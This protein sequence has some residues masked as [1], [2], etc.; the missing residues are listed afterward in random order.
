[1]I[2]NERGLNSV[3]EEGTTEE[4]KKE[5]A[6]YFLQEKKNPNSSPLPGLLSIYREKEREM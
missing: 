4:A 6:Q 2:T 1:M 3:G 5:K